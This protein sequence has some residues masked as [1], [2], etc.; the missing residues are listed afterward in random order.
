MES[1]KVLE[2]L[3]VYMGCYGCVFSLVSVV[4]WTTIKYND[5]K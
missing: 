4:A 2:V 5:M 3:N 1:Y